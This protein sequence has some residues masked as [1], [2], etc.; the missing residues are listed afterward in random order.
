MRSRKILLLASLLLLAS[1]TLPSSSKA[2]GG[3][4]SPTI[5]VSPT[6]VLE[7]IKP[8]ERKEFV[9]TLRNYGRDPLPLSGS[10]QG[11][12]TIEETGTPV[13]SDEITPHSAQDWLQVADVDVI[14]GPGEN[15]QVRVV[16]NPPPSL[17]PGSYH[18]A[19]IFQARLPSYYFDLDSDTRILPA[20]S[21][22]FFLTIESENLPT[23]ED[24]KIT[25]I[26]VPRLV[27]STPLSVVAQIQN[28]S[29]FYVQADA[30]ATIKGGINRKNDSEDIGRVMILPEGLR[31]FVSAYDSKLLPGIYT[32]SVEL[33]QG[34]KVLVAS[35]KFIALP[36][37]F[38]ITTVLV[39]IVL[40]ALA[41]R[42]R[43]KRA[44]LV[45][46]GKEVARPRSRP[47]LR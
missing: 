12:S 5:G 2:Q 17:K 9:V 37:Q 43:F 6:K 33:K 13:F 10:T 3:A 27:V 45:L 39:L 41:F 21:I 14:I 38:V 20:I 23:V 11:I 30:K 46:R 35:A 28:P 15:Q 19:A 4:I 42:N 32:A 8:G 40:F 34:D 31:R 18:A 22:L 26:Q 29:N 36:W 25:G 47:T 24:L 44:L 1:P 7:V 16:A